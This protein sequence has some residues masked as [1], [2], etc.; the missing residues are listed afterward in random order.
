MDK[1]RPNTIAD[2]Q[3]TGQKVALAQ[4]KQKWLAQDG[5]GPAPTPSASRVGG[6]PQS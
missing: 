3:Q 2:Q 5:H 6:G 1:L 4:Q